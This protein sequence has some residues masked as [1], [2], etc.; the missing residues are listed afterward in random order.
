MASR[1]NPFSGTR[2]YLSQVLDVEDAVLSQCSDNEIQS[3]LSRHA[4]Y[5]RAP[6]VVDRSRAPIWSWRAIPRKEHDKMS[7]S[8][9]KAY[10]ARAEKYVQF[11]AEYVAL[12]VAVIKELDADTFKVAHE[13]AI[14]R[15]VR[16]T[17]PK[18]MET[19]RKK[20]VSFSSPLASVI[21]DLPSYSST[22]TKESPPRRRRQRGATGGSASPRSESP[23]FPRHSRASPLRAENSNTISAEGQYLIRR[24][25]APDT[26]HSLHAASLLAQNCAA[27]MGREDGRD[28]TC[29]ISYDIHG[30][31]QRSTTAGSP[32]WP[33]RRPA[34]PTTTTPLNMQAPLTT[35][36]QARC[37]TS[38]TLSAIPSD[39]SRAA[40]RT[41]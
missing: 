34:P 10:R 1:S 21:D 39:T 4:L 32:S 30:A 15:K 31:A 25:R 23:L 20:R 37:V 22:P 13:L 33:P 6:S 26:P 38:V 14:E 2:K 9:C 27:H 40:D 24:P 16:L 5:N 7:R 35:L 8:Q 19:G 17:S 41:P 12:P 3:L 28:C 11:V 29:Q 36:P 18:Q